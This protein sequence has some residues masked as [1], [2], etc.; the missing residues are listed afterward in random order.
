MPGYRR[1]DVENAGVDDY[2]VDP[3][4]WLSAKTDTRSHA[5]ASPRAADTFLSL[6][7]LALSD[8]IASGDKLKKKPWRVHPHGTF[9]C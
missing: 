8:G 3:K 4:Y 2:F 1:Y 9:G 7:H 5:P 6:A